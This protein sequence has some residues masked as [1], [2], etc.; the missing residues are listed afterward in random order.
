MLVD[1]HCGTDHSFPRLGADDELVNHLLFTCLPEI[2]T[3]ALSSIPSISGVFPCEALYSNID[4]LFWQAKDF[5]ATEK[6]MEALPWLLWYWYIWKAPNDKAFNGK[7]I[8]PLDTVTL[9]SSESSNY[10]MALVVQQNAEQ[11]ETEL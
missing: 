7:E 4:F 6:Q 10:S 8:T 11:E 1:R 9:A 3:W 2:Q 5:G